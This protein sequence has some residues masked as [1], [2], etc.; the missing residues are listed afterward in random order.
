MR[1][2]NLKHLSEVMR[3]VMTN[4]IGE[5]DFYGKIKEGDD[6]DTMTRE[7]FAKQFV[8]NKKES[9]EWV[10]KNYGIDNRINDLIDGNEDKEFDYNKLCNRHF[11]MFLIYDLGHELLKE[12]KFSWME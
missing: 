3:V 12:Y 8:T 9:L 2:V 4:L 11:G 10:H 5:A 7:I 6:I 1:K